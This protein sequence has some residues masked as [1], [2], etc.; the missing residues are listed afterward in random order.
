MGRPK[1]KPWLVKENKSIRIHPWLNALL[2]EIVAHNLALGEK[3]SQDEVLESA[4]L[5]A[6]PWAAEFRDSWIKTQE[7]RQAE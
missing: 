6:I 3:T 1:E 2:P 5:Q 7:M 4:I